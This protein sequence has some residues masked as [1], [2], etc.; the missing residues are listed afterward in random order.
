[1]RFLP[2]PRCAIFP[3]R[4]QTARKFG[5]GLEAFTTPIETFCRVN[6]FPSCYLSSLQ[7]YEGESSALSCGRVRLTKSYVRPATDLPEAPRCQPSQR[8]T[9]HQTHHV[10][11]EAKS[12]LNAVKTGLTGRTVLLPN[13]DAAA[14]EAHV[15]R[16]GKELQPV[17]ERETQ[18]VQ[19]L[20]DTQ[21]RLDRIPGLEF[22]LFALGH[23]RY[24]DLFEDETDGQVRR[25]LLD[26]HILMTEAKHFKNLHLQ[27]SRLRRQYK[28]DLQELR[29]LQA[30][31]KQE[32]EEAE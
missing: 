31:R 12:S 32:G 30:E 22:G 28:Q 1:M 2:L 19:S 27:E 25:A 8:P 10:G 4:A 26:A 5:S 29:K 20:A 11:R 13:E 21:W 15:E 7:Q 14:Y 17:G 23:K 9:Q 24:A 3:A 6:F 18:L 16:F